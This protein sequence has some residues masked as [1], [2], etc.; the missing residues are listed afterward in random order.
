LLDELATKL[1]GLC[2]PESGEAIVKRVYR[3]DEIYR[4]PARDRAPDL[5]AMPQDGY[6]IKGTF[7]SSTLTGRGQLVGMHKYDNA[8]FFVRGRDI[9]VDHASVHDV[10]PTACTFLGLACPEDVD[11]RVVVET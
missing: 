1:A 8:T 9:T 5:L 7:E 4:G 2:D 3:A 11:G 10:L 6:D